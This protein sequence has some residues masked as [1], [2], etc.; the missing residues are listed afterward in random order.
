[1]RSKYIKNL[2]GAFVLVSLA[3]CSGSGSCP[4]GTNGGGSIGDV[5][6]KLTA[7]NQY[8]A[9]LPTTITAYLTMT[10]TSDVNATNLYYA[11]P[12]ATNYTG[13]AVTV[14]NDSSNPCRAIAAHQSCT[15]PVVIGAYA[16]P[17][18]FTVTATPSVTSQSAVSKLLSKVETKLGLQSGTLELTANIGLTNVPVNS[19][20]GANG[21]TFL[22]SSTIAAAE[23]GS[24][25]LSI[26]GVVNSASAGSFNT[27]NLTDQSGNL[28]DF[29]VSSGNSGSGATNLAQG[30]IVTFLLKI[31][32][33]ATGNT[34][35][36]YGQTVDNN[37]GGTVN[38]GTLPNPINVG[39]ATAGVLVVQPTS[40]SLTSPNYESQVVTFTN[41]GN[42]EVSSLSI[43]TPATPLF[44]IN[45]GCGSSLAAG[46][47]CTYVLGSH[48]T[49]GSSGDSGLIASYNN[50]S[51]TASVSAQV[52]YA[53]A[54]P[55]AGIS[56]TSGDNPNLSFV[57]NTE[58]NS[59]ASQLTLTNIGNVSESN[60]VFTVPQYFALAAGTTGTPCTLSGNTVTDILAKNASCTL[61]LTY[62]NGTVT[63]GAQSANLLV[64]YKYNGVDAP[65]SRV[66][67]TYETNQASGLLQVSSPALPYIF[68]TI[69][70][71]SM[72]ESQV[73]VYTNIGTGTATNITVNR[74]LQAPSTF[75]VVPSQPSA[76]NDCGSGHITSLAPSAS[77][78]V[79]VKFLGSIVGVYNKTLQ[80]SY[81]SVPSATAT[82]VSAAISGTVLPALSAKMIISSVVWSPTQLGGNGT[83]EAP[84]AFESSM[85]PLTVNLT[86]KND[87]GTYAA[88]NFTVN[89]S[90]LP[91]GFTLNNN[92]C[93]SVTLAINESCNV[94]LN[95]VP[96]TATSS[97]MQLNS[98]LQA[99]WSDGRGSVGPMTVQWD[100]SGTLQSQIYYQ[101]FAA[102]QVSAVMSSAATGNPVVSSVYRGSVFYMVFTLHDGYNVPNTAYAVTAPAG[103]TPTSGSCEVSSTNPVC[104]VA[105]TAPNT[106]SVGNTIS[107]SGN[108]TPSP[109]TFTFDVTPINQWAWMGG[110]STVGI[111]FGVY[112][113]KGVASSSNMPG[114]HYGSS[115][116]RDSSNNMWL[117]GGQGYAA[118]TG[119]Y[120]ND[121]WKYNPSTNQW[122]WVS[123]TDSANQ[124][125]VYGTKGVASTDNM[126]SSRY[127]AVS[128]IDSSN[129]LW[130]FGGQGYDSNST[131]YQFNDLWKYNP[132][133]NQWTWVSGTNLTN[134]FGVYGVKGT[135]DDA[136][137]P[138]A[139]SGAASWTDSLGN[140][141]LFGGYGYTASGS[142]SWLNDLWKYNPTTNQW[143]WV[144]GANI[145][146]QAGIY[147]TK[148]V[149]SAGNMPGS[150]Y[151][152]TSWIDSN[153]N[154]WLFGGG[155][156]GQA[157]SMGNLNDLWKY[158]PTTDEWTW[159]SGSSQANQTSSYGTKGV[160]SANNVPGGRMYSVGWID[161]SNN[162]FLFGGANPLAL[163]DLWQYNPTTDEWT[164]ISG[165]NL[166]NQF[167]VYGTLGVEN[168][169]NIPGGRSEAA[170][171]IDTSGNLWLFGGNGFGSSGSIQF[172]NDLWK[173]YP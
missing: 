141:W 131:T 104:Y 84:F 97:S 53:G 159:I 38:Q 24:T 34:F 143:T 109:T 120:L 64:D 158:N 121:L 166:T 86:Y 89:T 152:A 172:L 165:S 98:S 106:P 87:N 105:I 42:G 81:E 63:N 32:A 62:T 128:W 151:Y 74:V 27:I 168:S 43:Q 10:N 51:A 96:A 111:S 91:Q 170:G 48:A 140:F 147:G 6:L 110:E 173:Y 101:I 60:F 29:T 59:T 55:V 46:L 157:S 23:S 67:L 90:V 156:F 3:A 15:F 127:H 78:Q 126:P 116:W 135:P 134:Q 161:S 11:I 92:G 18:A 164:W 12:T 7:P 167:G 137:I 153:D 112:G 21:I 115:T 70:A 66:P 144:S 83:S 16:N 129:N 136:N 138:G 36:F 56:V 103:F 5:T 22:Y 49:P 93:N 146:N 77:C 94:S 162:L 150:R 73:F 154:L 107:V 4:P 169:T 85:T 47:S 68:P 99:T 28:L 40:F 17:G 13:V 71:N 117:F 69:R 123:G 142:V 149:S 20:S 44:V 65:Q 132:S 171:W 26:V 8:P 52:H 75:S 122:T 145:V 9:G 31:P 155:P 25:L 45:N 14:A 125:A 114:D 133:T 57:A 35:N 130:L 100:N 33:S 30:S 113:T 119:G 108:P 79:T 102:S 163:N 50:G 58:S 80:V 39:S 88:N 95:Y 160:P 118:S 148:G 124:A 54:N 2:L 1:M 72:S 37:G 82:T 76:A 139:R 19:N 41:I 61:T